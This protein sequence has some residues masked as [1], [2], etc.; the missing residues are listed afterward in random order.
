VG[1]VDA[2]VVSLG[3]TDPNAQV[4]DIPPAKPPRPSASQRQV[5]ADEIY[6]RQLADHY[7]RRAPQSRWDEESRYRQRRGSDV[8]EER[9]YSFFDGTLC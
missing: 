2:N 9:D 6:A 7:N 4:E 3:M 1:C 8:S 5:E